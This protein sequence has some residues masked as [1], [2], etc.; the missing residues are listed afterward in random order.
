[1]NDFLEQSR[2]NFLTPH[3]RGLH[4]CKHSRQ[5]HPV[6]SNEK[7]KQLFQKPILPH[8]DDSIIPVS[9]SSVNL[10]VW[11]ATPLLVHHVVVVLKEGPTLS[12]RV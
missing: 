3:T 4:I 7:T 6:N 2:D 8:G 5:T 10:L 1:M 12:E 9:W 11:Y